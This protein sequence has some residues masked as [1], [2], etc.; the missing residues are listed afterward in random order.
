MKVKTLNPND[1]NRFDSN[2]DSDDHI[3]LCFEDLLVKLHILKKYKETYQYLKEYP[4]KKI[5]DVKVTKTMTFVIEKLI[6][7]GMSFT[8]MSKL[9][10]KFLS[11]NTLGNYVDKFSLDRKAQSIVFEEKNITILEPL[12]VGLF[13]KR[14]PKRRARDRYIF[15]QV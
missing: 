1:R 7:E 13:I 2:I 8:M 14:D 12:E 4:H 9:Y 15:K 3:F 6:I 5:E 11:D 10:S